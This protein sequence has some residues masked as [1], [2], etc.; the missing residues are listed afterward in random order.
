M[1]ISSAVIPMRQCCR[2]GAEWRTNWIVA[3]ETNRKRLAAD[4]C[5]SHLLTQN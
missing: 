3:S 4:G 5:R 2:Q 1:F